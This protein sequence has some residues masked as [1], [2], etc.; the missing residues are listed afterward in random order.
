MT[1]IR[2]THFFLIFCL[3]RRAE[4]RTAQNDIL[5]GISLFYSEAVFRI[6]FLEKVL[7]K[8]S[9]NSQ[10]NTCFGV[11]FSL[12]LQASRNLIK[13]GPSLQLNFKKA[14]ALVLSC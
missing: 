10:E 11:S 1:G 2:F 7:L 5:Q 6:C 4:E 8:V 9:Q 13:K 3:G 12:N 14:W